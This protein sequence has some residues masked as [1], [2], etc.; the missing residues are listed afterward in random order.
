MGRERRQA[1]ATH[2]GK[3][4]AG[5]LERVELRIIEDDTLALQTA[6][7]RAHAMG[8]QRVAPKERLQPAGDVPELGGPGE[9]R[10]IDAGEN[11]NVVRNFSI[12]SNQ[13]R[14]VEK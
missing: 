14:S 2:L 5:Q 1:V 4:D 3:Q 10:R 12:W 7:V 13:R 8:D 9:H 11:L 6:N